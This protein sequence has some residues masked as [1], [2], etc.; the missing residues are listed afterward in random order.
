[1]PVLQITFNSSKLWRLLI[2]V[3]AGIYYKDNDLSNSTKQ[4]ALTTITIN[5][6]AVAA[7]FEATYTN[8][9]SHLF[10]AGSQKDGLLG[11]VSTYFWIVETNDQRMLYL[12]YFI[13]L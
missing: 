8:I 4:F 2:L 10:N 7:F 5:L 9:F 3:L 13:W 1:M 6:I 11:P 12:Y